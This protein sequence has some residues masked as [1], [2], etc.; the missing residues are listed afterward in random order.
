MR[1]DD[2]LLTR[3]D[4]CL[5]GTRDG[6]CFGAGDSRMLLVEISVKFDS[7]IPSGDKETPSGDNGP[8]STCDGTLS[9]SEGRRKDVMVSGNEG[10]GGISKTVGS[11]GRFGSDDNDGIDGSCRVPVVSASK[12]GTIL[13]ASTCRS[14]LELTRKDHTSASNS[15]SE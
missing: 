5:F 3:D 12:V 2:A 6:R 15:P 7:R 8:P 1:R 14:R 10:T 13:S 4:Q 9:D 11:V